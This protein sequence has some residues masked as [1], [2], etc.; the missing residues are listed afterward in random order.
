[1]Y[2]ECSDAVTYRFV[3]IQQRI[4]LKFQKVEEC[5]AHLFSDSHYKSRLLPI[6]YFRPFK[7]FECMSEDFKFTNFHETQF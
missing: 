4:L 3:L 6:K 2:V 1:M 5:K 7:V